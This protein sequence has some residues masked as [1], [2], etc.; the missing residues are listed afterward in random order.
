MKHVV[1]SL[2]REVLLFI[3]VA[4]LGLP[5]YLEAATA[6]RFEK[7][8]DGVYVVRDEGGAW[9]GDLSFSIT[10]QSEAKYQAR[11]VLDLSGV[12]Q[13][14]W[15]AAKSTRISAYF[16]VRDYSPH[17]QPSA[18]GLDEA[19]EIVING[20]VHSYPT[21]CGAPV[22]CEDG[23]QRIDW[24]DFDVPKDGLVRGVNE[25]LIRKAASSKNDDYLYLAIDES[26]SRGNSS[27]TFDGEHW[28]NQS[29]NSPGGKGE[30]M[31][32]LYLITR[33][34]SASFTW[35]PGAASPLEDACGLV[36]YAGTR[37]GRVDGTGLTLAAGDAARLETRS[38]AIDPS[39]PVTL[40]INGNGAI[41]VAWL[42][43]AGKASEPMDVTLPAELQCPAARVGEL[44]GMELKAAGDQ[45]RVTQIAFHGALSPRPPAEPLDI[46]PR[47]NPPAASPSVREPS[48][49]AEGNR[50][51]LENTGLKCVFQ[52]GDRL[53]LVSLHNG[54][55][56]CE[57]ATD[58]AAIF[59]FMVEVGEKRYAGSR[60]FRCREIR[61]DGSS[62][63]TADLE[64]AE[65]ALQAKFTARIEQEGLRL[66]LTVSNSGKTPLD[67]KLAFPHLAA[68][69][70]SGDVSSDY[71]Y[72]PWGGGIIA[73]RC[74]TL[75]RGYGDHEAL[76][77][78]MDLFSPQRGGGMYVRIDDA[79]GW[80]KGFALRKSVPGAGEEFHERMYVTTRPEF[81]WNNPLDRVAGTGVACEYLRRTRETGRDFRPAD[82]VIATHAG[83]W[84]TAMR[85]Y[86]D[87]AHR[88]WKFRPS[89]SRLRNV[90]HMIAAGWGQDLLFRDGKYRDDFVGPETDCTELMSWWDWAPHGPWNTPF[91]KLKDTL[92][93]EQLKSWEPYFVRDPVSG[94]MMW[95]NQPGDYEGYNARFGGLPAFRDAIQACRNKGALVT[96]YTDP[97]RLDEGSRIGAAHGKSWTVVLPD[98]EP[99][100]GYDV[101]N[102][103][104]DQPEVR[105]WVADTMKRVMRETG[106]DGIRL[107]EYGHK[108]WACFS[109][110]HRHSFAEYGVSQWNKATAETTRMVRAAMDEVAPGSV[111]TTEHPGY[112][113]LMQFIEGCITYDLTVQADS[114]RPLEC[115]T[116]RFYFPEC[117]AF[118][119]DHAGADLESKKK[120]WNAVD[121][122]GR[123]FP[124][125]M[126]AL[127][128]ENEDVYQDGASEP[129]VATLRQRVYANTFS[130]RVS[131][132]DKTMIHLYNATGHTVDAPVFAL[133]LKPD[134]HLF[135][136]LALRELTAEPH[137]TGQ[138]IR[139]YMSPE[140]VA[141]V[142]RLARRLTAAVSGNS[143]KVDVKPMAAE[144]GADAG[145]ETRR[146]VLCDAESREII[147]VVAKDGLQE[148]ALPADRK[149]VCAKLLQGRDLLD[150][151]EIR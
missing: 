80:H 149:A 98:G 130:G 84:H 48:Y 107:D 113:Y 122:F 13:E 4:V 102:P 65:P 135:D 121:S 106:A 148:I 50:H 43:S 9:R 12:P 87:W 6:S 139:L 40:G 120:I 53:S 116:Q 83:D 119:L 100:K 126:Y 85:A 41:R 26:E 140:T 141:C 131:G 105:Q 69:T 125:A 93:P 28:Q 33:D 128:K 23:R 21:N 151:T 103:C 118:E 54:Y 52:A 112:D 147:S 110:E 39:K 77:Q 91:A 96:L 150:V 95:N 75:R 29:L 32:R 124:P 31:V 92:T 114:L 17:L 37:T 19:F 70:P 144:H 89:P 46:C 51:V 5:A 129:L 117:K 123:Y 16:M 138:T 15:D 66:G 35:S 7:T 2:R 60:D 73:D 11:K 137:G 67:F 90:H 81:K 47:I 34:L 133:P 146:V 68:L 30:Y 49:R 55:T 74:A 109:K 25:V 44:A 82:A 8:A 59:L 62:G 108:G 56:D 61:P 57:M 142:A 10:H 101:W 97:F 94:E 88:V 64:L 71:Y 1:N 36:S 115:N 14:V 3:S 127:L 38:K 20:K 136:M 143:I 145:G 132:R 111:L 22:Y 27:V 63:F 86:A 72:F 104:H 134:Q 58:S 45:A 42:D 79:E 18:N 76:Y 78:L 24:Y 99:S